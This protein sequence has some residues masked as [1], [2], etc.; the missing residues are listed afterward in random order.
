MAATQSLP[1]DP[2][3][4]LTQVHRIAVGQRKGEKGPPQK[5]DH[6]VITRWNPNVKSYSVDPAAMKALA[7]YSR[8]HGDP[9]KPKRLPIEV[10]YNL[11]EGTDPVTGAPTLD[12]PDTI[13]W[14]RMAFYWGS[15]AHCASEGF[16]LKN[17][18]ECDKDGIDF[19]PDPSR[20]EAWIGTARKRDY[21]GNKLV[22]E[23]IITCNPM[24]CPLST[25]QHTMKGYEGKVVCKPQ[26]M[27]RCVL[28]FMPS[29]GTAAKF[30][31]TSWQTT[32]KI[33]SGLLAVGAHSRG[34]L[35]KVPLELV[36]SIERVNAEGYTSPIVHVEYAGDMA[37]LQ[38]D[39]VQ[40]QGRLGGLSQQISRLNAGMKAL[41]SGE[42]AR[43]FAHEFA[44]E[45]E[46]A[47]ETPAIDWTTEG[48]VEQLARE[49]GWT[50][51]RLQ[52]ERAKA[53]GNDDEVIAALERETGRVQDAEYEC[54]EADYPPSEYDLDAQEPQEDEPPYDPAL[55]AGYEEEVAGGE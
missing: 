51:A 38:E 44:H 14:T 26:T 16:R 8:F 5:L 6:F 15:R 35:A 22:G 33:R 2:T 17:E 25:G 32:Q 3:P 18:H 41:D 42:E 39:V 30:V 19:P 48:Y 45:T 9:Q 1:M 27:L 7:D 40:L 28:P 12:V 21:D 52:Q 20:R 53:G 31:T 37:A 34:W 43:A 24:K 13:L 10:Y 49:A 50:E 46:D 29:L 36:V 54:P 23:K 55:F 4:R 11:I 47:L